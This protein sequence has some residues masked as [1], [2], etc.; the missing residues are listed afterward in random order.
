MASIRTELGS[1]IFDFGRDTDYNQSSTRSNSSES[2]GDCFLSRSLSIEPERDHGSEYHSHQYEY[3]PNQSVQSL[4]T[5]QFEDCWEIT[6]EQLQREFIH[7]PSNL[8]AELSKNFTFYGWVFK[9]FINKNIDNTLYIGFSIISNIPQHISQIS[10]F[11]KIDGFGIAEFEENMIFR[12][13]GKSFSKYWMN[14]KEIKQIEA[15]NLF[16]S[17][18]MGPDYCNNCNYSQ[19]STKERG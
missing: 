18:S 13:Y 2:Q 19:S 3:R 15:L 10:T 7:K 12:K 4:R 5:E 11:G 16:Y 6:G 14:I 1:V 8:N 17:M 9:I